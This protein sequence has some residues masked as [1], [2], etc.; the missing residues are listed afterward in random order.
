MSKSSLRITFQSHNWQGHTYSCL[1]RCLQ[2]ARDCHESLMGVV[3]WPRMTGFSWSVPGK[4]FCCRLGSLQSW[5]LLVFLCFHHEPRSLRVRVGCF[6]TKNSSFSNWYTQQILRKAF[7]PKLGL[8]WECWLQGFPA[9]V[10]NWSAG[11]RYSCRKLY[12]CLDL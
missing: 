11:A 6:S 10:P 4:V 9:I 12:R 5:C 7:R 8:E 2:N 3:N 1:K